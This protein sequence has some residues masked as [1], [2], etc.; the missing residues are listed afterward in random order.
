MVI[1][2]IIINK[3]RILAFKH[4]PDETELCQLLSK[5]LL[6]TK[7]EHVTEIFRLVDEI[8]RQTPNSFETILGLY[9]FNDMDSMKSE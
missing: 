8:E 9:G 5:K 4:A 2:W 7:E 3:D 6:I 1:A